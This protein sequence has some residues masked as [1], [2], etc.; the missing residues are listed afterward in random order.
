M[1]KVD[2]E[3]FD[4]QSFVR[5]KPIWLEALWL[6]VQGLL[7]SSWVPGS[8]HRRFV[9]RLFGASI[10]RGVC[11]KPRVRVKFP[12]RL[13]IAKN[14]WIGED[15]WIDNL[16]DVSIGTDCCLS[17]G[18]YICTGS[19]DWSRSTFN[20]I[21]R[22]VRLENGCWICARATVGPGVTVGEGAVLTIGSVA[23]SDLVAWTVYQG[24]PA[25]ARRA[26]VE[27]KSSE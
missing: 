24:V 9:L 26:R 22:P 3:T 10:A 7:F 18:A 1:M 23:T 4:Q 16:A 2:L 15:V 11:I 13:S 27:R 6:I 25:T 14:S 21:T 5:G 20:L 8:A 17:Q 12:W 19:H